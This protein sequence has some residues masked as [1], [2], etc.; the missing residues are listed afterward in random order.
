MVLANPDN[1]PDPDLLAAEIIENI[2]AAQEGLKDLMASLNGADSQRRP[3][4][5]T[6]CSSIPG[7]SASP[8]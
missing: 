2:E 4:G 1:L 8:S 5:N 7:T 6:L 3:E